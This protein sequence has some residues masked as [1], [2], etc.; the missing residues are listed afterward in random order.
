[1]PDI[2]FAKAKPSRRRNLLLREKLDAFFALHVQ[3]AEK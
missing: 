3:V 2:A 1:M